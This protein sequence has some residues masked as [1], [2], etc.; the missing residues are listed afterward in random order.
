MSRLAINEV[1]RSVLNKNFYFVGKF[2]SKTHI[3]KVTLLSIILVVLILNVA[4]ATGVISAVCYLKHKRRS[5]LTETTKVEGHSQGKIYYQHDI[6]YCRNNVDMFLSRNEAYYVGDKVQSCIMIPSHPNEAYGVCLT[7]RAHFKRH[8]QGCHDNDNV[9][10]TTNGACNCQ[11]YLK[12]I[13]IPVDSNEAYAMSNGCS[14]EAP[15]Y[16]E[17]Q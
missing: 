9:T 8:F 5:T 14:H 17:I 15:L 4:M 11:K 16:E 13:Q 12:Q 6:N 10:L 3:S 7:G 2:Q 1:D